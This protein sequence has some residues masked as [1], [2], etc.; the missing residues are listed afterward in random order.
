MILSTDKAFA[1]NTQS[2]LLLILA[3]GT[4]ITAVSVGA[5][6][7]F[8]VN[9]LT[10]P[11]VTATMAV[12][13]LSKGNLTTRID[14]KGED[15]IADLG[16]S[17]NRMAD[18]LQDLQNNQLE[19][20]ERLER[21]TNILIAI[22][23][24]LHSDDLLKQ[25]VSE[26]RIALAAHR[27]VIYHLNSRN[28]L[29]VL[30]ES[31]A[32]GVNIGS[33]KSIE[34]IGIIQELVDICQQHGLIAVNNVLEK[35]F[36][37]EYL[38]LMQI[39]K[40]KAT[41][42]TPILKDNQIFGFLM[43]DYCWAPH[44]WQYFEINFLSQLAVQVGLSL[45]RVSLIDHTQALKELA[46]HMSGSLNSQD[47]Y[48]VAVDDIQKALQVERVFF[49]KLHDD[50][51]AQ[52]RAIAECA[53]PGLASMMYSSLTDDWVLNYLENLQ[54]SDVEVIEIDGLP[55]EEQKIDGNLVAPVILNEQLFGFLITHDV[56]QVRVWQQS[57]I[58]LLA[59]LARHIG[60]ALERASVL[61]NSLQ[62]LARSENSLQQQ[63]DN[64]RELHIQL[65]QLLNAIAEIAHGDLTVRAPLNE[66]EIGEVAQ[67]LNQIADNLQTIA[68]QIKL[69]DRQVN[70]A[71][72]ENSGAISQLA[73]SALK[74]SEEIS[75]TL[76]AVENMQLSIK[77]VATKAQQ[78]LTVTNTGTYSTENDLTAIKVTI[79]Q[80]LGLGT[81]IVTAMDE[82]QHMGESMQEIS[83]LVS[84]INQ[85]VTETNIVAINA[86]IEANRLGVQGQ[87]FSL[88]A[89]EI[90]GLTSKT[91]SATTEIEQI[92]CNL[93]QQTQKVSQLLKQDSIQIEESS[94]LWQNH[95]LSFSH[96]AD[97]YHQIDELVQSIAIATTSQVEISKEVTKAMKQIAKV[98][99][100]TGNSSRKFSASLQKTAEV[101]QQLQTTIKK[102]Q[103]S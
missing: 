42:V 7:V 25:A 8:L 52:S 72:A 99:K 48:Q 20:T 22:R 26:S 102:M 50:S 79:D 19:E 28:T 12:K 29:Q 46:I 58:D 24:S 97:V 39:L 69:S 55:L 95:W 70:T 88:L 51:P 78:A 74:Q 64:N 38:Q 33:G 65:Q 77:D 67:F 54:Q 93:Q 80:F 98:S 45:E 13:K 53:I 23:Q 10:L 85:I 103:V 40:I 17:I 30:A 57:E 4:V 27:V 16:A 6:V 83:R 71:L 81:T 92:I 32:P 91:A 63:T 37:P 43:A 21:F 87:E 31:V 1:F 84:S 66:G 14:V 18:Q 59:Q 34:S 94:S 101:S 62:A 56:S 15:E 75:R 89:E 60:L 11:I 86:G 41:L 3:M 82:M 47:I 49:Y 96:I 35:E 100:M 73:I 36:A 68:T 44:I 2:Q 5:A 90:T 76:D 9:R 61:E